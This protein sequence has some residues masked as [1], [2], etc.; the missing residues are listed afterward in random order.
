MKR[1]RI[2][3]I[4][5]NIDKEQDQDV[6]KYTDIVNIIKLNTNHNNMKVII[7][8]LF[9]F[10]IDL[11]Y[12]EYKALELLVQLNDSDINNALQLCMCNIT[13]L[14]TTIIENNNFIFFINC[15][16]DKTKKYNRIT[17]LCNIAIL[18][19]NLE[20]FDVF[21]LTPYELVFIIRIVLVSNTDILK[22][23]IVKHMNKLVPQ[24]IFEIAIDYNNKEIALFLLNHVNI[25]I[26][27]LYLARFNKELF[28]ILYKKSDKNILKEKIT[29]TI[30][31]KLELKKIEDCIKINLNRSFV[32]QK[33]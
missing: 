14:L 3:D 8:N 24:V 17:I 20:W 19:K 12:I 10:H 28:T 1:A 29:H 13:S 32:L 5:V 27:V 2:E 21:E 6:I 4:N 23:F 15:I 26:R 25:T 22:T 33:Q 30:S 31:D 11:I 7:L 18:M 16:N 9:Y